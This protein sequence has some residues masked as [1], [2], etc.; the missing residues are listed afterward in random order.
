[1][2]RIMTDNAANLP[3]ALLEQ[4]GIGEL[5]LTYTVD[6]EPTDTDAE[7]DGRSF[8]D[9]MRRG[10]VVQTSMVTPEAARQGMEPHLANGDDVLF[11][12]LSGGV[13]GTCWGVGLVA[14]ELAEQYP[15]R[16]IRVLDTRGASLGEGLIVLEAARLAAEGRVLEEIVVRCEELCG[17]MRQHFMVDDLKFLRKGGR[18]SGGAALAG[19]LLQIKPILQGDEEGKIV[20]LAKVRGKKAGMEE[21]VKLYD[22]MVEDRSAP[23]GISHAGSPADALHVATRLRQ[24]GCTGQILTVC[25]EPVTGAH[26]GPGMLAV[27]F[28]SETWR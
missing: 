10:A 23:V 19:T 3:K 22:Q 6:G 11:V 16:K 15:E 25:H 21:M 17:K 18:I 1:M 7:F 20:M 9:A 24:V 26:V 13:S 28:F 8:Y 2:V 14:R 5:C 27:Y 12:G 4:Y